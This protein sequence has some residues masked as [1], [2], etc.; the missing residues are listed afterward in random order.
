[1]TRSIQDF[2]QSSKQNH[3]SNPSDVT[4]TSFHSKNP[5]DA[6]HNFLLCKQESTALKIWLS[7]LIS[8]NVLRK[9]NNTQKLKAFILQYIAQI[10]AQT[11]EMLNQII[12]NPKFQALE[13]SWRGLKMLTKEAHGCK[14]IKIKL[15]DVSWLELTKDIDRAAEFDQSHLFQKV[16]NNEYGSPGGEP[17]GILLGDYY[18]THKSSQTNPRD[19][20]TLKG[21]C[22]TASAAFSP[23]ITSAKASFFELDNFTELHSD[24]N[25]DV[26]FKGQEF[27]QWRSLREDSDSRF[28]GITLPKVIM[29]QPY[30]YHQ[31]QYKGIK[32]QEFI[33]KESDYLWGNAT[34]AFGAVLIREFSETGW[35]SHIR[36]SPK[37]RLSGGII[38]HIPSTSF[39]SESSDLYAR[40]SIEVAFS[41]RLEKDLSDK[42]FIPLSHCHNTQLL[43]FY[44]NQSIKSSPA[45]SEN[46]QSQK[47]NTMIQHLLCASRFAHYIKV[48]IRDKVGSYI[49]AEDC[50]ILLNRW[51]IQYQSNSNDL[52]IEQQARYPLRDAEVK[53]KEYPG[54]P[55]HFHS[56]IRLQPHYQV[57]Q[58]VSELKLST[59]LTHS[60]G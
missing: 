56:I 8:K 46:N 5:E 13:A 12:H 21:I 44:S 28:I 9:I 50:E 32:F 38:T 52:E 48:M 36:G 20:Q 39:K 18:V 53:V 30:R 58:I 1:M 25:L 49:D 10:D 40:P 33:E 2:I 42:G 43:A 11:Q 15:L 7:S 27:N 24:L 16:Y 3:P 60:S 51:L 6:L 57:D 37:D 59:E 31:G 55:G 41:Y 34:Y 14:Q 45:G 23:F 47:I 35:F 29:R 22:Q 17:F 54:R 4:S 19:I 26:Y